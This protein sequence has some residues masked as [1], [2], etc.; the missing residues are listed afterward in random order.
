VGA[1]LDA[2][3]R[4]WQMLPA[5]GPAAEAQRT[6]WRATL[7][8][9]LTA[10]ENHGSPQTWTG[11]QSIDGWTVT[12]K[13]DATGLH[14]ILPSSCRKITT[15]NPGKSSTEEGVGL[16]VVM[17][18]ARKTNAADSFF[19]PH[20][21]YLP[22]TLTAEFAG[23]RQVALTFYHTGN[24][25]KARV[26][27]TE[28]PLASDL[29]AAVTAGMAPKFFRR[30]TIMGLI[31]PER[32]LHETGIYAPEV[33][34]PNKIPVVL[35][36]G[37]ES[38]PHIWVNVMKSI[39]TDPE[40]QRNYQVWYFLYP[41]GITIQS[42]AAT[43]RKSLQKARDFYDPRHRS[44]AMEQMVIAGHS[45]GGLLTNMQVIDSHETIYRAFFTVPFDRLPL[46]RNNLVTVRDTL[47]FHHLPFLKR[48]VFI[49]TPHRG[50]KVAELSIFKWLTRLVRPARL[51]T[52]LVKEISTR[53][54]DA[55]NPRLAAFR[56][57]GTSTAEGLSPA[58]PLLA[59][60][61]KQPILVPYHNIIAVFKPFGSGKP[62]EQSSDG[63]VPYT[64]AWLPGA[65]S[66]AIVKGFHTCAES[67][68]VAKEL[69][70]ILHVHLA[71]RK[72]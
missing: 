23:E 17:M 37:L 27:G 18:Q 57:L 24:V 68:E 8:G 16:P 35:V 58:H 45:M 7:G 34:D 21:R 51:L 44:R 32:F 65:K 47:H 67:P 61:N 10:L 54:R 12:F 19:P 13:G 22:A 14:S 9:V 50:S 46:S 40:L 2:A 25:M 53:A 66:T 38:A 39:A 43:L 69:T 62:V 31:R 56:D 33:Y 72:R 15:V 1:A 6:Q 26:R 4:A 64:S 36:H 41:T 52:G 20:G 71:E 48:A 63:I 60:I 3:H 42:A 29:P 5:G 49:A 30:Y 28:R 55:L 11:T 59:A 70:R